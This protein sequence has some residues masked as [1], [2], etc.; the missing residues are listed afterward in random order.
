V[1]GL[2]ETSYFIDLQGVRIVALNSNRQLKEQAEWLD[3]LLAGNKQTWTIAAFHHPVFS[4]ARGRDNPELRALFQPIFDKHNVDLVLTGHDHS[5]G[6]SNL[7]SGATRR[8]GGTVYVVSVSGPKMYAV[9]PREWMQR[10]AEDTQLFQ[11]VRI[12]GGNLVFE[13]RTARGDLYDS[14]QL[15]KHAKGG[16]ELIN[17][18]PRSPELLRPLSQ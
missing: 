16:N 3:Q 1:P 12:D 17:R 8:E 13:S 18:S 5:Y 2:E 6:R 14:F 15:R 7:M 4:T 9:T 11:I 10:K